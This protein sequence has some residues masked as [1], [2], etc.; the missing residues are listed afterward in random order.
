MTDQ[1]RTNHPWGTDTV[2]KLDHVLLNDRPTSS[3]IHMR[4]AIVDWAFDAL[5]DENGE[6]DPEVRDILNAVA[7]AA[8]RE[9]EQEIAA[10]REALR[11]YMIYV[12]EWGYESYGPLAKEFGPVE[13]D[14]SSISTEAWLDRVL[15]NPA[16]AA[17]A[18]RTSGGRE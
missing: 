7:D 2:D 14:G 8:R 6:T 16:R 1:Q 4:A 12:D 11:R 5:R 18:S 9:S 3:E 15:R 10:L 17:L 13:H